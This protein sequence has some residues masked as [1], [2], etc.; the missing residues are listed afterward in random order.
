M[1]DKVQQHLLQLHITLD[2]QFNQLAALRNELIKVQ[3]FDLAND[4]YRIEDSIHNIQDS[5]CR[6]LFDMN[7]DRP[8][9]GTNPF[10][11]DNVD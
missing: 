3:Q 5:V 4:L 7:R 1:K 6:N 10:L 11:H 8:K 2:N 9:K